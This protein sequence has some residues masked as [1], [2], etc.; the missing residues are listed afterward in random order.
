MK[1]SDAY[2]LSK[3]PTKEEFNAKAV[4]SPKYTNV[5][6]VEVQMQNEDFHQAQSMQM[7]ETA[8][9]SGKTN[10]NKTSPAGNSNVS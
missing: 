4:R 5:Q 2:D 9:E 6:A 3:K 8:Q 10:V 1:R 7:R